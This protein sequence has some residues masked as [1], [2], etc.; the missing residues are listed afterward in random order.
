MISNC[1]VLESRSHIFSFTINPFNY[2]LIN[3]FTYMVIN[4][5]TILS[6][7][8]INLSDNYISEEL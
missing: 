6:D 7:R 1:L 4:Y 2:L 5:S 8:T 3:L